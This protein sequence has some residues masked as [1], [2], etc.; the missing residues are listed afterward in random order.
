MSIADN[1]YGT[2][3][4]VEALVGRYTNEGKFDGSTRPTLL[5]VEAWIDGVSSLVNVILAEAGFAIPISQSDA[6]SAIARFVVDEVVQL[7][8]GA[9]GAGSYAP[10][11]E[12]LRNTTANRQILHNAEAFLAG[13]AA[14]LEHLGATRSRAMTDG[15]T[16]RTEDDA[17]DEIHPVFQ[18]KMMGNQVVDW[19]VD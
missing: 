10:G 18:R 4:D 5:Q 3:A 13:H 16:C 2:V 11:S 14:G 1:S 17:G 7:C 9:N 12:T 8:H 15:L 6:A 19:D